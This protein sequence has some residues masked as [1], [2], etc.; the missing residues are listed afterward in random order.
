MSTLAKC[1]LCDSN[2]AS[3]YD[4]NNHMCGV[5]LRRVAVGAEGFIVRPQRVLVQAAGAATA[6]IFAMTI[7][8]GV[9]QRLRSLHCGICGGAVFAVALFSAVNAYAVS[10]RVK[11]AC[12]S[13]YFQHCSQFLVGS[14][15][16][17]QCMR[18]VG[19]DLST[20]CLVA[21]VEDG[22]ITKQDV[23]RHNAAKTAS[24]KT[25]SEKSAKSEQIAREDPADPKDVS[26]KTA[27]K[28][29]TAKSKKTA[30]KRTKS[31]KAIAA[32][33]TVEPATAKGVKTGKSA[34]THKAHK[35]GLKTK[36][37]KTSTKKKRKKAKV[38]TTTPAA[39]PTPG[40]NAAAPRSKKSA[41]ASPKA[42]SGTAVKKKAKKKSAGTAVKTKKTAKKK[43]SS[44]K[45][46][47]VLDGQ[48]P[49][50]L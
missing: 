14:D 37:T 36:T 18:N 46:K 5:K 28:K 43:S 12:R 33:E 35:T 23:E 41:K 50:G 22:E 38:A 40:T 2:P 19:E 1:R 6:D 7:A 24:A 42:K 16:L 9:V 3:G 13:D 4:V 21:L 31:K 26:P 32:V 11:S 49:S 44:K 29:K 45:A 8:I 34:K 27:K 30:K 15:E 47:K 20:P 25:K 48:V 17:R 39:A 10:D